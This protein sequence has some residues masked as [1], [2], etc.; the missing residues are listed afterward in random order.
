[1]AF[2]SDGT[3]IASTSEDGSFPL[4]DI[5]TGTLK[6]G[7]GEGG[8]PVYYS[9]F[10]PDGKRLIAGQGNQVK[11]RDG[12]DGW[13]VKDID[14][15]TG[16]VYAALYSPDGRWIAAACGDGTVRLLDELYTE[17]IRFIGFEGEEWIAITPSN[18]YTASAKGDQYLNARTGNT[19]SGADRYRATFYKPDIIPQKLKP[20]MIHGIILSAT[21]SPNGQKIASVSRNTIKIWDANTR[22]ELISISGELGFEVIWSPDGNRLVGSEKNTV[23]IWNSQNGQ[24]IRTLSGYTARVSNIAMS[25][26]GRRLAGVSDDKLIVWNTE[27]WGKIAEFSGLV[28]RGISFSA[29]GRRLFITPILPLPYPVRV[30]DI[31][32]GKEMQGLSNRNDGAFMVGVLSLSHDGRRL[33]GGSDRNGHI[34]IWDM[35]TNGLIKTLTGPSGEYYSSVG[36]SPDDRYIV[37]CVKYRNIILWNAETGQQIKVIGDGSSPESAVYSPDGKY[38][39]VS[40][41]GSIKVF[42]VQ[43]GAEL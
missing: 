36:F 38:L 20:L 29:D 41:S 5:A 32:G 22:R 11:I 27:T 10:S 25:R 12:S 3:T 33:I 8:K 42:D 14:G 35:N 40:S 7:I 31:D 34:F 24:L 37:S 23:K 6:A 28:L 16:S 21:P 26:D 13:E 1:V 19:V 43:T 39:Y 9:M 18:Y 30:V 4:W 15:F 17:R 2:S